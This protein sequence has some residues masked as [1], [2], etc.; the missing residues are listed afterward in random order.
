MKLN[1]LAAAVALATASVGANAAWV[2]P[3]DSTDRLVDGELILT[4]WNAEAERAVSVDLGV[5][6]SDFVAG[7]ASTQSFDLNADDINWLGGAD[8]GLQWNVMGA[9]T[10]VE[11]GLPGYGYYFTSN[12]EIERETG[13][14]FPAFGGQYQVFG[15]YQNFLEAGD[16]DASENA[17][18]R[19]EGDLANAGDA[20]IWGPAGNNTVAFFGGISGAANAEDTLSAYTAHYLDPARTNAK[21]EL[22]ANFWA[23]DLQNNSLSY[24]AVPVPAAVWLFGSAMLGLA[25]IARRKKTA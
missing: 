14:G 25:G 20:N 10:A 6:S 1:K 7:V 24:S 17:S 8:A 23:L 11:N 13:K 5:G 4:V 21:V 22:D 12:D 9:S 19:T 16:G 3:A 2:A 18:Y 15:M